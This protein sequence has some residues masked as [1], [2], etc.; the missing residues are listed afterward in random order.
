MLKELAAKATG[1]L[2]DLLAGLVPELLL[3]EP[4]AVAVLLFGSFARGNRGPFSDLDVRIVTRGSPLERDR[5]RVLPVEGSL[6]HV[7]IG[8]RALEEI[9]AEASDP[10]EWPGV[11]YRYLAAVP[12]WQDGDEVLATIHEAIRAACPSPQ[13]L[14]RTADHDIESLLEKLAKAKNAAAR[15]DAPALFAN[16]AQVALLSARLLRPLNPPWTSLDAATIPQAFTTWRHEP[17]GAEWD[18]RL[19][20]GFQE[21]PR[22]LS[23]TLLSALRLT[24]GTL[25]FLRA[26]RE[27]LPL[28]ASLAGLLSDGTLER[29]ALQEFACPL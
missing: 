29:L 24:T 4:S 14:W 26:H 18:A 8:A 6:L 5:M 21:E 15:L 2:E 17:S 13:A 11:E 20:L 10:E 7:S 28:G 12:L 16:T 19:C 1:P 23:A 3:L 25:A 22:T 27:L 9:V